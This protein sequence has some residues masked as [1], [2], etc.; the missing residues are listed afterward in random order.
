MPLPETE[1][2][3]R[4]KYL[5]AVENRQ[6]KHA[7]EVWHRLHQGTYIGDFVYGANDGLITTFA[8]VAGAA[9][10][11]FSPWV[12]IILG[13]ANLLAD[14]LSMGASRFLS[15]TAE[16]DFYESQKH[17]E[18]WEMEHFPEIEKEEVRNI[19]KRWG[20]KEERI[21]PVLQDLVKDK[22]RWLAIMMREE[23]DL[24][25]SDATKPVRHGFAT[26][27]AFIAVGSLP[28]VPYLFGLPT[29]SQFLVA[30]FTTAFIL[31]GVGAAR[32]LITAGSWIKS[33]FEM[34]LIGGSAALLAFGVGWTL[35][36]LVNVAI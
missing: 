12:I 11:G 18:K 10:A 24:H 26:S 23:L 32:T 3:R 21:E 28:L 31:F 36:T 20:V 33:G 17:R 25:E 29:Q 35:K 5:K 2:K 15:I 16:R 19:L 9:G 34:L 4:E 27:A 1:L 13:L 8:V 14:G 30:L 22:Q 6:Y 7:E